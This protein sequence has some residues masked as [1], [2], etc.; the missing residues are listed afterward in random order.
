MHQFKNHNKMNVIAVLY[1]VYGCIKISILQI[2]K[3]HEYQKDS[4]R[5]KT[6]T[7]QTLSDAQLKRINTI[8]SDESVHSLHMLHA[9]LEVIVLFCNVICLNGV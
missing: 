6:L 8:L 9:P 3:K 4:L 1:N 2:R 5:K 7:S